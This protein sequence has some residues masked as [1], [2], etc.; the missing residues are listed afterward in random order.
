MIVICTLA[1]LADEE[2]SGLIPGANPAHFPV[3]IRTPTVTKNVGP[4]FGSLGTHSKQLIFPQVS[5]LHMRYSE[6]S[7]H[8]LLLQNSQ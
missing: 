2:N 6:Q 8:R 4:D 1:A 7:M 5:S 3:I